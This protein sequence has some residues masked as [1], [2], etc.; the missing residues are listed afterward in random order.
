MSP[1]SVSCP[2]CSNQL[3]LEGQEPGALIVC[4]MCQTSFELPAT[5]DQPP[6]SPEEEEE[7]DDTSPPGLDPAEQHDPNMKS[8][9]AAESCLSRWQSDM[10]QAES[11][12]QPSGQVPAPALLAMALGAGL[13]IVGATLV[14]LGV[15]ALTVHL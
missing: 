10:P 2:T 12:Y 13:G 5:Y 9:E 6:P 1:S 11:A 7:T 14:A 3:T 8:K 4:P 15:G